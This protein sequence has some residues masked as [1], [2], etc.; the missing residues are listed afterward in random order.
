VL[1]T[2]RQKNVLVALKGWR[3]EC[4]EIRPTFAEPPL[5]KMERSATCKSSFAKQIFYRGNYVGLQG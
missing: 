5:F 1:R 3:N 4:Y 2:I